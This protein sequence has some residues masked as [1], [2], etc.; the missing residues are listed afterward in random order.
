MCPY[1]R[2]SGC[3]KVRCTQHRRRDLCSSLRV[4]SKVRV[5]PCLNLT[6]FLLLPDG[7]IKFCHLSDMNFADGQRRTCRLQIFCLPSANE[8]FADCKCLA[9]RRQNSY[10][11][12]GK[13][14]K[15]NR[16]ISS[17]IHTSRTTD[18]R[19]GCRRRMSCRL[20]AHSP[21][22]SPCNC[23]RYRTHIRARAGGS[24][25]APEPGSAPICHPLCQELIFPAERLCLF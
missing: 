8:T 6:V 17:S 13:C 7:K 5:N 12:N 24:A 3:R 25:C 21:A 15:S 4:V 9:G 16:Q 1:Q 23:T 22:R 20:T 11:I 14:K 18:E 2:A 10:R 19:N